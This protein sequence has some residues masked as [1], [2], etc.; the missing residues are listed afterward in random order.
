[1]IARCI[2]IDNINIPLYNNSNYEKIINFGFTSIAPACICIHGANYYTRSTVLHSIAGLIKTR[3]GEVIIVNSNNHHQ[4]ASNKINDKASQVVNNKIQYIKNVQKVGEKQQNMTQK[5]ANM[6][7][8]EANNQQNQ[9]KTR[10]KLQNIAY[11]KH[12]KHKDL[13]LNIKVDDIFYFKILP[14]LNTKLSIFDSLKIYAD[15]YDA[16]DHVLAAIRALKLDKYALIPINM[17]K[18]KNILQTMLIAPLLINKSPIWLIEDPFVSM[19]SST[20]KMLSDIINI[21]CMNSGIVIYTSHS[22]YIRF[23]NKNV[24]LSD[25]S[26]MHYCNYYELNL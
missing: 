5:E 8:K 19:E 20:V 4:T 24:T 11:N 9:Q 7:Q 15:L 1:M 6:T 12:I 10:H 25:V 17:I 22:K 26:D 16:R 14:I 23:K 13:S 21:K 2:S 3:K 18:K